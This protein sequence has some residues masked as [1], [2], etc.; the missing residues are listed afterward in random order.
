MNDL[1][2]MMII[3]ATILSV[4]IYK[5]IVT[6]NSQKNDRKKLE[7]I[8]TQPDHEDEN[9]KQENTN[10]IECLNN[11]TFEYIHET[12]NTELDLVIKES[13][14]QR[15]IRSNPLKFYVD[16]EKFLKVF[17]WAVGLTIGLQIPILGLP[18]AILDIPL[19]IT[20]PPLAR[21][22]ADVY[23]WFLGIIFKSLIAWVIFFVYHFFICAIYF[24]L[25]R[26]KRTEDLN[27]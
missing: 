6:Y 3:I 8:E 16:H 24:G 11:T 23:I 17:L 19:F 21:T 9:T 13:T 18:V 1:A 26:L 25:L 14:S 15:C 10:G 4:I 7:N 27:L 22:G 2:I 12:K 20:V 5:I